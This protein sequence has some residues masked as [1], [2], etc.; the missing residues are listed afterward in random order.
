MPLIALEAE[1]RGEKA[2]D[3]KTIVEAPQDENAM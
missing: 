3:C 1:K 2:Q